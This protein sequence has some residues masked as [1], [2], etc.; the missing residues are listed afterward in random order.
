MKYIYKAV[1]REGL[2]LI[3]LASLTT[4]VNAAPVVINKPSVVKDLPTDP[5]ALYIGQ[6]GTGSLVISKGETVTSGQNKND[7]TG[8]VLGY[9]QGDIGSLTVDGATWYDSVTTSNVPSG[10]GTTAVGGGGNGTLDIKNGGKASTMFINIGQNQGSTGVVNVDGPGSELFATADST[11]G[12]T[13]GTNG[14]G[15]LSITNG[16]KVTSN[17]SSSLGYGPGSSGTVNVDGPGSNLTITDGSIEVGRQGTGILNITSG[18]TV[19]S[20]SGGIGT[21]AG[22]VGTA[23][24]NGAGSV[25]NVGPKK[26]ISLGFTRDVNHPNDVNNTATGTLIIGNQGKVVAEGGINVSGNSSTLIIGAKAGDQAI[27]P[28]TLEA[29]TVRLVNATS[30]LVFNHSDVTG[31]YLFSPKV[32]G[33]GSVTNLSG[34][35]VLTGANTYT[36]GTTING[37]TLQLGN[38]SSTGSIVGN[39]L[40]NSAFVINNPVETALT[41]DISGTGTLT[42]QGA[43]TTVLSG[44]NS[45]T[46]KTTINAGALRTDVV[47]SIASSNELNINGGVF[48]LNSNNQRVNRLNGTGG[49]VHLNGATLTVN[50]AAATDNTL[51]AGDIID[52]S[53]KGGLTKTG[54]GSLT[55]S[56]KTGWTGD[57]H[58]DGGELVLDGSNGGAQL[59]SNIIAKD[60]TALSLR[61]G[62]TLTGWIDPTD[63]NIDSASRWNMTADSLVDDVN[64]A[65]TIN[66]VAPAT[67]PMT[68]GRTLTANNWNGQGG[69]VMLNT[70]LG[71][72]TSVTDKILVN[73]NTSGNTFVKVNNAGGG[74]AYTVQGIRVVEVKGQSDGTFTKSGRIVAGAYD[75]S[76]EKKGT[77][78]YLT[79]LQAAPP[80]VVPPVV[81]P[82]VTDPTDTPQ[83]DNSSPIVRPESAS[84]TANLAAAN[85]M[86]VTR[87]HDRLGEPQYTDILT[88]EKKVSSL[89][90]R[91]VGGHNRWKDSSGQISTQS[92]RYVVQLG[93]DI[94]QWS[95]DELERWHLGVMAGY[96]NEHSNSNSNVTSYKSKGS[97]NGYSV[98]LYATWYQNDETKQGMYLDSW[99][100]YGWFNNHVK[101]QDIQGESY[102]SSGITAS[103]ETGYTHKLGEFAGSQGSLN[104]WYIQPQAQAIWMGVTAEDHRESNGTRVSAEG[105]GNLQTR[106][107]VRTYLKG[108]NKID[109][110]KN[111]TFQPF[112]E[113]NWIHNTQDFGTR[114]DGVSISQSGARNLGEVK[115]GVEG[116]LNPHLNLWGNVGV[117]IG[118]KG[119]SDTAAMV[120]VKYSF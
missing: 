96:G 95:S 114:M 103:L 8:S 83:G 82:P 68:A 53:S 34:T 40:N 85:T 107:G 21:E 22:S 4:T 14:T 29:P 33:L 66:F 119:Y 87:L 20:Q 9:S 67:L 69:T 76:L 43:G 120:G 55:L 100:Q 58:I 62:A 73:G 45:Y 2:G 18:G 109:D 11:S 28:G 6:G 59:V 97:V 94:A 116:Q 24:V 30:S 75:Y 51:F 25:W 41:G 50:N 5:N 84:Y 13:V 38:G 26:G 52:G 61:N 65:G 89:W 36:G 117:Q 111:R 101:G 10:R 113:V 54:D 46:G 37:G 108:H 56:G 39:V 63:V 88:G 64:L 15:T 99:A 78:W 23:T 27:T 105:E 92:N 110:G 7:N 35:T 60:N 17:T 118:D 12:I 48:D 31:N 72:D 44:N 90:L 32:S 106:L 91:Q 57:T 79:N 47:D 70:V 16:G 80:V 19:N 77:D 112:V 42:Q 86:F 71:D 1:S 3:I 74:G 104:E 93:G 81:V 115:T 49:E 102:K 98:G